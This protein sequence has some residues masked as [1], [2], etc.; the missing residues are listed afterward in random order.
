MFLLTHP[1]AG[2]ML[3]TLL[4][5][6]GVGFGSPSTKADDRQ[7]RFFYLFIRN[8]GNPFYGRLFCRGLIARWFLCTGLPT[9]KTC[10]PPVQ[11]I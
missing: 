4:Q 10:R 7:W 8:Y 1:M 5:K 11:A 6:T 3:S 2:F 9:C